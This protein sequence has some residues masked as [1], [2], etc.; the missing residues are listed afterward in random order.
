[1]R[2]FE[3]AA[4]KWNQTLT[5]FLPNEPISRLPSPQP[6]PVRRERMRTSAGPGTTNSNNR[7]TLLF[8]SPIGWERVRVRVLL[9]N[10]QTKPTSN[11]K[12][13]DEQNGQDVG[14]V[15]YQTNPF[16]LPARFT[17]ASR[18]GGLKSALQ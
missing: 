7:V 4:H 11:R 17:P 10:Y 9:R 18:P 2:A 5:M 3:S 1:M 15:F 8:P 12:G 16:A 6:S 14:A 13:L